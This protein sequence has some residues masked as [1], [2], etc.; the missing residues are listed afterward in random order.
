MT[1]FCSAQPY[2]PMTR[3]DRVADR[4]PKILPIY[5]DKLQAFVSFV[6]DQYVAQGF[7]ELDAAKLPGLLALKYGTISDAA[8]LLGGTAAIRETFIGFQKSLYDAKPG[9]G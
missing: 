2:D 3:A 8:S 7:E 1:L 5:N 6:L 4:R 9:L